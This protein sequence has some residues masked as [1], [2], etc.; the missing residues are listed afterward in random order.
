MQQQS[1]LWSYCRARGIPDLTF[2]LSYFNAALILYT[3]EVL[4]RSTTV[5]L[6]KMKD[7]FVCW[8]QGWYNKTG[9]GVQQ[10]RLLMH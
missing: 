1:F 3:R 8:E 6:Q 10:P 9:S 5:L 2:L 4:E 7:I